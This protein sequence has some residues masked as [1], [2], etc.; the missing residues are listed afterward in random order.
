MKSLLMILPIASV[1]FFSCGNDS[2]QDLSDERPQKEGQENAGSEMQTDDD[3]MMEGDGMMDDGDMMSGEGMMKNG[4]MEDGMMSEEIRKAMMSKGMG[5]EMMEDMMAIRKLLM[6][7]EKINRRVENLENGV[8][9]WTTSDDPEIAAAIQKHVRQM[10]ERMK[11]NKPIRQMDPVFH[12]IFDNADKIELEFEDIENG[13][14]V[15]ETSE[16]A[17]V[18]KLIQQH[19]NQAVSEFV[20]QGMKRAMRPTPLPEG[21]K[22]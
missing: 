12:E 17:Q 11:E 13:I 21:Y 8:K 4:M 20:V 14:V 7:H 9:T 6:Q 1:I 10:K 5:P 18:V 16:D 22:E 2:K 15:V 19:A 3:G